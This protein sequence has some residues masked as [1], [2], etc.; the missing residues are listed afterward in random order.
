MLL[1]PPIP[2]ILKILQKFRKEGKIVILI[3][4]FLERSSII[5]FIE[6]SNY[7][8]YTTGKIRKSVNEGEDYEKERPSTPSRIVKCSLIKEFILWYQNQGI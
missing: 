8:D 5:K 1:H 7:F 2:L 3:V 4:F 6:K